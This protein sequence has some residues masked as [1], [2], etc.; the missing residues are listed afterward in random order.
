MCFFAFLVHFFPILIQKAK[1]KNISI[2]ILLKNWIF[3][4]ILSILAFVPILANHRQLTHRA[5]FIVFV[6]LLP[7]ILTS[8]LNKAHSKELFIAYLFFVAG[9][10]SHLI[11]DFGFFRV[12]K[13]TRKRFKK[14]R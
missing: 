2:T 5:W 4:S 3:L 7:I 14:H 11:L 8:N 13:I 10:L 12:F 6:P 1:F 9:A